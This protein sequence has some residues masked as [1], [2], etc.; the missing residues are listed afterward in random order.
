LRLATDL[1]LLAV[2]LEPIHGCRV[3]R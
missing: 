3:D 1:V 2:M